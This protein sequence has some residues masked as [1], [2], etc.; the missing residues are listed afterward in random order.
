MW[1]LP[2]DHSPVSLTAA[3]KWIKQS[4]LSTRAVR[5]KSRDVFLCN[6]DDKNVSW[7]HLPVFSQM[8]IHSRIAASHPQLQSQLSV[9]FIFNFFI[10][11]QLTNSWTNTCS[12][13][14]VQMILTMKEQCSTW[15]S[16]DIARYSTRILCPVR[17]ATCGRWIPKETKKLGV[18]TR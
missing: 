11:I 3:W 10:D 13:I 2:S 18:M 16:G 12:L 5:A 9:D 1:V 15:P 14:I 8:G 17:V 7:I 6:I 4:H